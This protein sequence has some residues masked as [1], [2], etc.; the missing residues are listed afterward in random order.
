MK[1]LRNTRLFGVKITTD[2][3]E[4]ILEYIFENIKKDRGKLF[5]TTPNPEIVMYAVNHPDFK[6]ILNEAQI[7]LPDGVGVSIALRL[8]GKGNISRITGTDLLQKLCLKVAKSPYSVGFFGGYGSIALSTAKC[9]QKKYSGLKVSYAQDHWDKAKIEGG[10]IDILFVAM[11]FPLQEKWIHE[12]LD[13]IPVRVAIGVGGAFDFIS[14]K[15]PRA[16]EFL[17]RLGLE[18]LFRLIIQPWRIKRQLALISFSL[19]TLKEV[20]FSSFSKEK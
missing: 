11:G 12:N 13:K 16:P 14:G 15:I 1:E 17:R 3:E 2:S 18:W 5:I 10:K 20:F 7:A 6:K 8:K 19:M 9:L 4:E